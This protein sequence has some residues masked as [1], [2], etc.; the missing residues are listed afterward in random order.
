MLPYI[1]CSLVS[2]SIDFVYYL[3]YYLQLRLR[4]SHVKHRISTLMLI[5]RT[6]NIK[7]C[8]FSLLNITK[9]II[10][11]PIELYYQYIE[12]VLKDL[13]VPHIVTIGLLSLSNTELSKSTTRLDPH[14]TILTVSNHSSKTHIDTLNN[15]YQSFASSFVT[16]TH[17]RVHRTNNRV[18]ISLIIDIDH[19][20]H[21]Q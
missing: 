1:T 17:P 16:F 15:P 18:D 14:N 12:L 5:S 20:M 11:T 4:L 3:C 10:H 8:Y 6:L 19:V 21:I 7:L 13:L 9:E 2:S